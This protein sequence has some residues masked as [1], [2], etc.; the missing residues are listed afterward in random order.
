[1]TVNHHLP[2]KMLPH[3]DAQEK[4]GLACLQVQKNN[5]DDDD[6][7][8]FATAVD[9]SAAPDDDSNLHEER[10]MEKRSSALGSATKADSL[11]PSTPEKPPTEE[12]EV[13]SSSPSASE[14]KTDATTATT[15][16]AS[17][18]DPFPIENDGT[19]DC[20]QKDKSD[21]NDDDIMEVSAEENP[22]EEADQAKEKCTQTLEQI[23]SMLK[24][25]PLFCSDVRRQ[26]WIGEIQML[27]KQGAP[28]TVF[29]VLGNTGVGK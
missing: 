5:E 7:D 3:D 22:H 18:D 28:K 13:F 16:F 1:M 17:D 10:R 29:G 9:T 15:T 25:N 4:S 23:A 24:E 21:D 6:E 20:S 11:E 19:D 14:K 12:N 2:K 8:S 27:S 26:E